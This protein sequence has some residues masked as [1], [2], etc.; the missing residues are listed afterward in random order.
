MKQENVFIAALP[1]ESA[2]T[3]IFTQLQKN[4]HI[5]GAEVPIAWTPPVDLHI[6]LGYLRGFNMSDLEAL[7]AAFD[8]ATEFQTLQAIA[9]SAK[10]YGTAICLSLQ[11][12]KVF[13]KMHQKLIKALR[14]VEAQKYSFSRHASFD[15]HITIGRTRLPHRRNVNKTQ[16]E[17]IEH[18]SRATFKDYRFDIE[19]CALMV[20]ALD[21]GPHYQ[22]LAHYPLKP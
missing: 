13:L 2:Q 3:D 21:K 8:I 16:R 7:I 20:R 9:I 4:E 1:V 10:I 5:L 12:N 15:P 14:E 18:W 6:T 22:C 11:P 19:K 17:A